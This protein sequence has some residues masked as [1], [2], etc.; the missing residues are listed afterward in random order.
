VVSK[1]RRSGATRRI[2]VT[3]ATGLIGRRVV[4]SLLDRNAEVVA[5]ARNPA[6][7]APE[8]LAEAELLSADLLSYLGRRAVAAV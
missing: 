1:L 8:E 7:R 2:V 6:E 5:V 4:A 3:G